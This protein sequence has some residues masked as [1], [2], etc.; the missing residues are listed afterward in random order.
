MLGTTPAG[1]A[2]VKEL[3]EHLTAY[4]P[5]RYPTMFTVSGRTVTNRVTGQRIPTA[6][7]DMLSAMRTLGE[8]VEEE[9]FLLLPTP[10]GH[11]LVAY[12]CCFPSGF[13]PAEK[14]DKLLSEIHGPVPGYDKIGPSMERFFAKLEH[15]KPVKR[16]NVSL[17][18]LPHCS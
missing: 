7:P 1:E 5:H 11:R 13:D 8:T 17:C 6:A 12:I 3:Y 14:L 15:G 4:L 9:L 2:A 18:R 16:G 10:S